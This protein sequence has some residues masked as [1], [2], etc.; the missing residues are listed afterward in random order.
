MHRRKPL[1][2]D[3]FAVEVINIQLGT[4]DQAAQ[5]MVATIGLSQHICYE[6]YAES[7]A[8]SSGLTPMYRISN[9]CV[10]SYLNVRVGDH[11]TIRL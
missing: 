10:G 6:N 9:V 2:E 1:G 5:S 7:A 11:H 4:P 8:Q 3:S